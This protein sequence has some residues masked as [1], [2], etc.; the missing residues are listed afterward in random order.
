MPNEMTPLLERI[1]KQE[2]VQLAFRPEGPAMH[3]RGRKAVV[4]ERNNMSAEGATLHLERAL[5]CRAVGARVIFALCSR[6]DGR[7]Y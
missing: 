3:S 4:G 7:A 1:E 5:Q 6:P 2:K